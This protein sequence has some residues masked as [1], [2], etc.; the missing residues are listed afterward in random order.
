[1]KNNFKAYSIYTKSS[2]LSV[3]SVRRTIRS[4]QEIGEVEVL[5]YN[6]Y[7]RYQVDELE[8]KYS[9]KI[10]DRE[11]IW[12]KY[13][14]FDSMV[15]CFFSHFSLWEKSVKTNEKIMILEHD[16]IFTEKYIDF[17]FEGAITIGKPLWEIHLNKDIRDLVD[18]KEDVKL[19]KWDCRCKHLPSLEHSP[20]DC[21]VFECNSWCLKGA[22]SYIITPKSAE[23]L[24]AKSY[25]LGIVPADNH[26]NRYN[27]E[28]AETKP[29]FAYQDSRFSLCT[30]HKSPDSGLNVEYQDGW[31][32]GDEAWSK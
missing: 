24:I 30:K 29:S 9:F 25:D 1:M 32:E 21:S 8:E 18:E 17:D 10:L 11:A 14:Y 7:D 28:I 20:Y 27:I 31:I 23:K 4:A 2:R 5:P 19:L 16:A 26:I 3:E 6:G 15:A 22:H 12:N 13:T